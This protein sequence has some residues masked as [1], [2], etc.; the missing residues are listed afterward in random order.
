MNDAIYQPFPIPT[1]ARGHVWRHAPATTR[2]R[3]FHAESEFNWVAAGGASFGM[4]EKVLSVSAGDLLWWPPGIDHVLLDA[5]SDLDLFVI[6]VTPEFSL[7]ALSNGGELRCEDRVQSRLPPCEFARWRDLCA[8]PINPGNVPAIEAR[9]GDLWREAHACRTTSPSVHAVTRRTMLSL[10]RSTELTRDDVARMVGAHPSEL[11]R[12][13]HKDMGLTL[14]G[15]RTRLRLLRFIQAV[16]D[17]ADNWLAAA[18]DA[19]FGSY[20]QCHRSFQQ[21]L[22]CMPRAFFGT[23]TR[24][25][26]QD[27]FSSLREFPRSSDPEFPQNAKTKCRAD[28][29]FAA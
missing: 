21:V 18:L 24:V 11:S 20:S 14:T 28:V 7:R 26:M 15:Y 5:S 27:A 12:H 1:S 17:G 2:P 22:G 23:A 29:N 8:A 9:V 16:D 10:R 19:G 25:E 6:G 3:H 13:F 4:G